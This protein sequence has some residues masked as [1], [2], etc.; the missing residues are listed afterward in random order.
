[1][2]ANVILRIELSNDLSARMLEAHMQV[3][4]RYGLIKK[5]EVNNR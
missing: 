4:E 1:M 3:L 2:K 5:T